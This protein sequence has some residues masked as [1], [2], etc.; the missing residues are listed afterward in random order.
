[1]FSRDAVGVINKK[2][3]LGSASQ[4]QNK[5]EIISKSPAVK[6]IEK[7]S[8]KEEDLTIPLENPKDFD[9]PIPKKA[10]NPVVLTPKSKRKEQPIKTP[11][12]AQIQRK[13]PVE[14]K[15]K[16]FSPSQVFYI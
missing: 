6:K 11:K 2:P 16:S 10:S 15:A 13:I 1:M 9:D 4:I 7:V 3:K 5:M 14:I 8:E 12:A